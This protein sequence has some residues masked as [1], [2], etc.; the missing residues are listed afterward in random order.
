MVVL[1]KDA[2]ATLQWKFGQPHEVVGAQL[3]KLNSFPPLK[4][5][6]SESVIGFSSTISEIVAVFESLFINNELKVLT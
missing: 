4:Q 5:H 3:D 2:L 1:H 6:N